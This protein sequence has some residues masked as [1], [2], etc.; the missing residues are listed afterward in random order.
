L[1]DGI[2]ISPCGF[3]GPLGAGGV[4]IANADGSVRFIRDNVG[5]DVLKALASP[6]H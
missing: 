3:G 5:P 4:Y 6:D 1:G 2:I